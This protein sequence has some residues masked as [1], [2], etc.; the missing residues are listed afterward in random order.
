ML[1]TVVGVP[2]PLYISSNGFPMSENY[3]IRRVDLEGA[4]ARSSDAS[5]I[6]ASC[7]E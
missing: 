2:N 5:L 1:E 4:V 3:R 7:A 6:N